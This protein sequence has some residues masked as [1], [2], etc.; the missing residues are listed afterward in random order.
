MA[1]KTVFLSLLALVASS[2]PKQPATSCKTPSDEPGSC[3]LR[4]KCATLSSIEDP[5]T[6]RQYICGYRRLQPKLC[7]PLASQEDKPFDHLVTPT[8]PVGDVPTD[9]E[10]KATTEKPVV[11]SRGS[12]GSGASIT[13]LGNHKPP[14]GYPSNLPAGCGLS[15]VSISKVV[16]GKVADPGSWPWMAAIYLKTD[17]DHKVSC[18]GALVSERHVVTAAHC[19]T[20]GAKARSIHPRYV[21]VRLGDHDLSTLDDNTAPVDVDVASIARHPSYDPRRFSGDVAVLTLA[22]P[23]TF[24]EY[25]RPL[26][27]PFGHLEGKD[28]SGYH[29]FIVGW[30]ATKFEGSGS[31][32][33]RE[34]QVPI[35]EEDKCRKAYERHVPIVKTQLCA[36]DG[37]GKKDT[38]QGD[39]GGPFV[40]P[41]DR[42]FY[43]VGVVSSGKDCATP[44]FPGIYTRVTSF[45]DWLKNALE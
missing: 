1:Q 18:G 33:L 17:G 5:S 28:I 6:L 11:G 3:V 34:A 38:C 25:V 13:P 43:I 23:V 30:G 26:C 4:H 19:V 10:P 39:S 40:L 16:G 2:A 27:L 21:S 8:P 15:N 36:G 24:N 20:V 22:T 37:L 44:G 29:G 41:H 42:R 14:P 31:D 45:L 12:G 7:C 35:W 32:V 9:S